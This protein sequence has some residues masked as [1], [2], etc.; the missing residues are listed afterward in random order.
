MRYINK[1]EEIILRYIFNSDDS[2]IV[3]ELELSYWQFICNCRVCRLTGEK[4]H[5]IEHIRGKITSYNIKIMEFVGQICSAV[6]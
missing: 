6:N 5:K 3:R 4:L 2:K 1:G